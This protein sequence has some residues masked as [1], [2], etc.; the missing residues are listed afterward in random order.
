MEVNLIFFEK[1]TTSI[2]FKMEE[3]PIFVENGKQSKFFLKSEPCLKKYG[4][5][6]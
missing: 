4:K 3:H 5:I 1:K 2:L 6:I